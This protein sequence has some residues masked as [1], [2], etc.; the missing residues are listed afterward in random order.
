MNNSDIHKQVTSLV[1]QQI[2]LDE[3]HL[4]THKHLHDYGFDEFDMIECVMKCEDTF[5]IIIE[6]TEVASLQSIN[7][8]VQCISAKKE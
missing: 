1:A 3:S 2:L 5:S 4:D 7:D 6:D 8:I